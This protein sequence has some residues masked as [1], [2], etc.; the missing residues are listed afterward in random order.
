MRTA[1]IWLWIVIGA[2]FTARSSD[3]DVRSRPKTPDEMTD[4]DWSFYYGGDAYEYYKY[5]ELIEWFKSATDREV[6]DAMRKLFLR[7]SFDHVKG[8]AIRVM[9]ERKI[10]IRQYREFIVSRLKRVA[11][12]KGPARYGDACGTAAEYS[13]IL[14]PEDAGL[15]LELARMIPDGDDR[16]KWNAIQTI[17]KIGDDTA[18]QGLKELYEYWKQDEP[19][20]LARLNAWYVSKG[21]DPDMNRAYNEEAGRRHI[22]DAAA[23]IAAMEARLHG[24]DAAHVQAGIPAGGGTLTNRPGSVAPPSVPDASAAGSARPSRLLWLLGV[25]ILLL[26]AAAVAVM[27]ARKKRA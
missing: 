21:L 17:A 6:E 13:E 1:R 14:L 2:A 8:A 12:S 9:K 23:A 3:T 15:I 26:S 11:E 10:S 19:A 24:G 4:R 27:V 22:A 25:V 5:P 20:R 18:L 7:T 16:N